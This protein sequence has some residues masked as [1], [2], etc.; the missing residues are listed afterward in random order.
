M[1]TPCPCCGTPAPAP[2]RIQPQGIQFRQNW[3]LLVLWE[4]PGA[5]EIDRE[6]LRFGIL[7]RVPWTCRAHRSTEWANTTFDLRQRAF[8]QERLQLA[9]NGWI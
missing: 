7:A 9:L 1:V 6:L 2:E 5:R 4:C 3:P 8:E